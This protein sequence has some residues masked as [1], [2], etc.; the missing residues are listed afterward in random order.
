MFITFVFT[1]FLSSKR[2]C[3]DAFSQCQLKWRQKKTYLILTKSS[4]RIKTSFP[5]KNWLTLIALITSCHIVYIYLLCKAWNLSN[6]LKKIFLK[7]LY[8][9]C[10]DLRT[11][12]CWI[13]VEKKHLFDPCRE[14]W[15]NLAEDSLNFLPG[16]IAP[17]YHYCKPWH[18]QSQVLQDCQR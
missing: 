3:S 4:N 15:N 6:K 17:I 12:T 16:S 10:F 9:I 13:F 1:E 11:L 8:Y 2:I 18:L 14:E 7:K 5:E